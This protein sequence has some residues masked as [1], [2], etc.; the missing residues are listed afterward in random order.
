MAR[1]RDYIGQT[2]GI[3]E[4][5][6]L[7]LDLPSGLKLEKG[8]LLKKV[9]V[10]Y[11][12]CG[13]IRPEM[14]NVVF[15]CHA[16]TGDAHVAGQHPGSAEP[17]GWWEGMIGRGRGIDTDRYCVV[18][19]NVLGGCKGTTGPSSINP[20]TG[21]PYGSS[22]PEIT[23]H[24]MVTVHMLLLKQL[25]VKKV[26]AVIGGSFGGMQALD[27]A[28]EYPD[29]VENVLLIATAAAHSTQAMSFDIIGRYAITHDPAWDGGDYYANDVQ[30]TDG[31]GLARRIAHIT[32]L[33]TNLMSEKF[34]RERRPE[35]LAAGEEFLR[36]KTQEFG[37]TFQIESYLDHQASTFVK[38]FDA[39]SYLHI[40]KALDE[41]DVGERHGSLEDA[42]KRVKA[43]V[44]IASLSGDWLFTTEQSEEMTE[45]FLKI[46][47]PVSYFNLKAPA[48]HDAFLTHIDQLL[49]AIRAFLPH[50]DSI[51]DKDVVPELEPEKLTSY[52]TIAGM[53]RND[54]HVLDF[55][56]A[57]GRLLKFLNERK[58]IGG[59]GI[60]I[61]FNCALIALERGMHVILDNILA[62]DDKTDLF[63]VPDDSFDTVIL[64]E[65][66]Q[67]LA[68]PAEVIAACLRIAD[69]VI[70]SFPNF[71]FFAT[72]LQLCFGGHMPVT[73]NLP[74]EW[75]DTPNIRCLTLKDFRRLCKD[76]G[77]RIS[78]A[79]YAAANPI[80]KFLLMLGMKNFGAER[81]YIRIERH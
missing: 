64:S 48:G 9:D 32:Y 56:C 53:T 58:N 22:F 54:A 27:W 51:R 8:G 13:N 10:A 68:H 72:R 46:G 40:T 52:E 76:K 33:S 77:Y 66:L 75:Y 31:L 69:S 43:E 3:V 50:N 55:G 73:K 25:G 41:F 74:Y 23:V 44:F 28:I 65:T 38:R 36:R 35:W 81:V 45:A 61:D 39:N 7:T 17:D 79:K 70:V 80:G 26:F 29:D 19:A 12:I 37:T 34:G 20:D 15:V 18:C 78:E 2:V 57:R 42:F 4:G 6:S 1:K 63:L 24:D 21:K 49:P 30:P 67:V 14:D 16:L 59:V 62:T 47:K 11:E 71:G 5:K 60:D